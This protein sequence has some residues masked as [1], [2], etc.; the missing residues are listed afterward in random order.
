MDRARIEEEF[1]KH[2]PTNENSI[3]RFAEHIA[4]IARNEALKECVKLCGELDSHPDHLHPGDC[5]DAIR[6]LKD[7]WGGVK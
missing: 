5:A 3:I 2:F 7:K 4:A 6:A 1:N